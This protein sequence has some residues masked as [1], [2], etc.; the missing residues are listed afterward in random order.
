M[1]WVQPES[2]ESDWSEGGDHKKTP[3]A[4]APKH[5]NLTIAIEKLKAHSLELQLDLNLI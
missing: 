3:S 5:P 2:F 1:F 4:I